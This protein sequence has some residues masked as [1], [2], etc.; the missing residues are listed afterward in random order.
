[1]NRSYFFLTCIF[2]I[3]ASSCKNPYPGFTKAPE[4]I[5]FKLMTIGEQDKQCQYGDYVTA[6]LSY[7]T[8]NDSVFFSGI[9]KF[10]LTEPDFPGSIDKCL[11]LIG[12]H[13]SAVFIISALDFFEKTL[14][15]T[16]PDYLTSDGKMKLAV[17][18]LD[19]Q[20]DE[21]YTLE[22]E[23]F[24]HWIEDLG[25]YEKVLVKQ[26]IREAKI[27]IPPIEDNIYYIVQREGSGPTVQLG[28]T[29]TIHYE[30]HFLNGAFFD[31]TRR[32][33]EPFRFVYGQQWQVIKGMEKAIGRMRKG[34]KSLVIIPSE[35]AFGVDGSSTGIVPPFT[36]VVFEVEI[37]DLN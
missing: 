29:I 7:V 35:Q 11:T 4:G 33:N 15:N 22:K 6:N 18:L 14:G 19:V 30:G 34:E 27:D 8:M 10:R 1:M 32:R 16:V 24:L 26:Y 36:P 21:E 17:K 5:Y 23:A 12:N 9:R 13:D 20:T 2:L 28:D 3:A 25:E 31:S 37:I